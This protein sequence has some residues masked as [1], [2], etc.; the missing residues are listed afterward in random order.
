ME[1]V[2]IRDKQVTQKIP[3]YTAGE[4]QNCRKLGGVEGM[5]EGDTSQ[6]N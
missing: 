5:L 2:E 1:T 3:P 6:A 4:R